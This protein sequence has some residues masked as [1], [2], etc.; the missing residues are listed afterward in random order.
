MGGG[1]TG[2]AGALAA[3]RPWIPVILAVLVLWLLVRRAGARSLHVAVAVLAGLV[4]AA[5]PPGQDVSVFLSQ[6]TGGWL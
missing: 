4:L 3:A 5:T 1:V 6:L 2:A